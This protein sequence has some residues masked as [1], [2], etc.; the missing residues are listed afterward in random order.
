VAEETFRKRRA[1]VLEQF[2]GRPHIYSTALF[3]ERY[4]PRARA[5]LRRSLQALGDSHG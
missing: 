5:N 4:E 1:E 2:L 3:R